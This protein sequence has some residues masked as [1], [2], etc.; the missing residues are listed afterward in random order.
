M[1]DT[2]LRYEELGLVYKQVHPE[3]PISIWNYTEK[4][5]WEGSWNQITLQ[6]R[7]LVVDN[8]TGEVVA[9]PFKKFF[10]LSEGKT[11][12]SGRYEIFEKL[13]GSLGILFFYNGEWILAS[14]GSFTSEQAIKGKKILDRTCNYDSLSEDCTYC[15]E[16]IYPENRIVVD[17][18]GEEKVVLTA[19]FETKTGVEQSLYGYELPVAK[20]FGVDTPLEDLHTTIKDSEEGYVV[21]FHNGDRCKIKGSEYL[22]LHKLMSEISSTSIWE[23]LYSGVKIEESISTLPDEFF[24]LVKNYEKELIHKFNNKMAEIRA[25]YI[26]VNLSLGRCD[27]KTFALFVSSSPYK[28]FLFSMRNGKNIEKQVWKLI[29]PKYHRL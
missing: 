8:V 26:T 27:D 2:L 22:R 20:M 13:D 19:V 14:R 11:N 5:Q 29:K 17:Y 4:V 15:F 10:N 1:I 9:R 12:I 23:C 24:D 3:L 6:A 16:I 18:F 21:R 7:G 25:E 28:S